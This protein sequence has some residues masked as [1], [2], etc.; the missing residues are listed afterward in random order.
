MTAREMI[1][2]LQDLGKE[3]LDRELVIREVAADDGPKYWTPYIVKVLDS[4]IF[5]EQCGK[6]L[7]A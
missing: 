1:K 5:G 2:A 3:N 7:I 6:I 4:N